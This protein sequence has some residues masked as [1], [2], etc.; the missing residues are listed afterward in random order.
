MRETENWTPEQLEENKKLLMRCVPWWAVIFV[1][2]CVGCLCSPAYILPIGIVS[3]V[4]V[5]WI[6]IYFA[7]HK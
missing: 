2:M 1:M 4:G 3:M 7:K 5:M 6:L